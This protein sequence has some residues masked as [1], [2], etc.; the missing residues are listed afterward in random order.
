MTAIELIF[1]LFL[2]LANGFFV[3]AEFALVKVR[4]NQIEQLARRAR[5]GPV[6]RTCSITLTP[7]CRHASWGL[8][9]A[10]LGLG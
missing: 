3:A 1:V 6:T 7:T 4:L 2:V 10:S 8:P 9:L 5:S